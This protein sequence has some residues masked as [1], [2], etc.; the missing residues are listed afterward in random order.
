MTNPDLSLGSSLRSEL[1]S[2]L[3]GGLA[4]ASLADAVKNFPFDKQGVT[5]PGLPYSAWQI[6]EHIRIAQRD[7]LEF[8]DNAAG[9]YQA[10]RW[11]EDYWP[12]DVAP[13]SEKAWEESV[14]AIAADRKA[15]DEL[16][17]SASDAELVR[18]FPWGEGQSLLREALQIADHN[19]YHV[20]ELIV[21]R[22]LLGCWK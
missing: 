21:V 19:A 8:S 14:A 5:P 7:M 20:G 3:D 4:H 10:K 17:A 1:T 15:F 11:P 18:A 2:L 9:T 16:I 13:P 12:K 22:R 6:L